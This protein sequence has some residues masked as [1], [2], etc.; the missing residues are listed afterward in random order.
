VSASYTTDAPPIGRRERN[1]QEKLARIIAAARRL[2]R[3]Q[4][5]AETTTQQIAKAARIAA[6]TLFLYAQSKEDLLV[7]VFKDE[8]EEAFERIY[9]AIPRDAPLER[10]V[11][12]LFDGFIAYHK[13]DL[14]IARA[15]TEELT[16][17]GNPER[18][19]D[20][21]DLMRGIYRRLATLTEAA[22]RRGEIAT[23]TPARDAARVFFAIYYQLLQAWLGGYLNEA[24]FRKQMHAAFALVV[25]G[26]RVGKAKR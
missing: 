5:Y 8:L 21:A 20:M 1:K 4:G 23:E 26:M 24:Q 7:L 25:A 10:Q 3:D 9:R 11:G 17:L 13:R 14:D 18:R 6:G 12:R 2:F 15:I 19:R 16:F 22:A